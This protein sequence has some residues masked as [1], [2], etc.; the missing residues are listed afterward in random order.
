MKQIE[1]KKSIVAQKRGLGKTTEQMAVDFG[2]TKKEMR[3]VLVTFGF[4]K[5]IKV[6]KSPEYEVITNN[7][8]PE[9]TTISFEAALSYSPFTE[10]ENPEVEVELEVEEG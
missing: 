4:M 6:A 7:D 10:P 3:E 8:I 9:E 2:I 1:I 5:P